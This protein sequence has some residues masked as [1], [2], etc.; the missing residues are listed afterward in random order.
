[1]MDGMWAPHYVSLLGKKVLQ[2]VCDSLHCSSCKPRHL[3]LVYVNV[4]LNL[5]PT[6]P[7]HKICTRQFSLIYNMCATILS[8]SFHLRILESSLFREL[9]YQNL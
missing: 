4:S 1:M 3:Q 6:V 7:S 9:V 5:Y 2:F 8:F